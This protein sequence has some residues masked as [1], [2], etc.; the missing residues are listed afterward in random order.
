MDEWINNMWYIPIME[1]YSALKR[2]EILIRAV[3]GMNLE[4]PVLIEINQ[5]HKDKYHLGFY[6]K[7]YLGYSNSSIRK[8]E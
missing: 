6:L 8:E 5:S 3:I 7:R 2:N 1:S 4:D